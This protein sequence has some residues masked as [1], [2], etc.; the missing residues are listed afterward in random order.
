MVS[1]MFLLMFLIC[2]FI[3]FL[4]TQKID[5]DNL[6]NCM[7]NPEHGRRQKGT[8]K[9]ETGSTFIWHNAIL[10]VTVVHW[11]MKTCFILCS[12]WL[13]SLCQK[14]LQT[15]KVDYRRFLYWFLF[16]YIVFL[17]RRHLCNTVSA[18]L[19]SIIRYNSIMLSK[20]RA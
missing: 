4:C 10:F 5:F 3:D 6:Y 20:L 12:G 1:L 15:L 19:R 8:V 2:W 17:S 14:R 13:S 11:E 7:M 16:S 9:W 18:R